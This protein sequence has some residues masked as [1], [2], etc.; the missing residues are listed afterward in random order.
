ML[1]G[2]LVNVALGLETVLRRSNQV[3]VVACADHSVTILARAPVRIY[4]SELFINLLDVVLFAG[5]CVPEGNEGALESGDSVFFNEVEVT[6]I[7]A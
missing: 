3:V 4:V 6:T 2:H 7:I 1:G 5:S